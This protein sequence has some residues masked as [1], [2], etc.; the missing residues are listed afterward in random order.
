[1][2]RVRANLKFAG[3]HPKR[4][5]LAENVLVNLVGQRQSFGQHGLALL[6]VVLGQLLILQRADV[7][8]DVE[9]RALNGG[10]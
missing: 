8:E 7:D 3:T 5:H 10:F 2:K 9:P 6:A 1:M 4:L